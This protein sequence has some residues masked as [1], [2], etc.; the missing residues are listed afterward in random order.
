MTFTGHVTDEALSALYSSADIVCAPSRY[1]SHG[2]VLL[3][4]MMFGAA[5]VTCAAG[6]I[7]EVVHDE[8]TALVVAPD[9]VE[10]LTAALRRAVEDPAL[11][12]R[13]G[14]AARNTYERRFEPDEVAHE[15]AAFFARVRSYGVM[16]AP[17]ALAPASARFGAAADR[18]DRGRPRPGR[19]RRRKRPLADSSDS[20]NRIDSRSSADRSRG[21]WAVP[22]RDSSA[23]AHD[24]PE[25]P[26]SA[27]RIH[28]GDSRTVWWSGYPSPAG[29][30]LSGGFWTDSRPARP[31][32]ALRG[33]RASAPSAA[34]RGQPIH[35]DKS[36]LE[37]TLPVK[38]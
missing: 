31:S 28:P 25:I 33:P 13:L 2:I 6:G 7:A 27:A 35:R 38:W 34:L 24:R 12:S 29:G 3:E 17:A 23:R 18:S 15:M 14:T 5:I 10:A 9:D 32:A 22:G 1:E 11:R 20:A 4:A 8:Q 21:G 16:P 26:A 30:A 37:E 36:P 19:T